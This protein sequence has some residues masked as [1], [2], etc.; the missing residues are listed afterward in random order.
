MIVVAMREY[1][2]AVRT[3][4][5]IFSLLM[6]P[7]MMFGSIGVQILMKDK[8]DTADKRI[9]VIDHTGLLIETIEHEAEKRNTTDI[10]KGE[11]DF[12]EKVRP[13]FVIERV[14]PAGRGRPDLDLA[15]SDRV[16]K[17]EIFAFVIIE[18]DVVD[19]AAGG[20]IAYHSNNATYDDAL[21]WLRGTIGQRVRELRL[22][23]ADIDPKLVEDITRMPD[24]RNLGLA[25]RTASGEVKQAESANEVV[26][27]LVPLGMLML[28]FMMILVGASPLV[29]SVLEEKMNRIAEVL[30]GSVSPFPLMM[31]KLLGMV[32][33]SLTVLTI[34]LFGIAFAVHRAGYGALFPSHLVGWFVAYQVLA[35][36]MFGA[37]FVAIGAAVSDLKEA[38]SL[39]TPVMLIVAA[40]MF[41]WLNVIKEPSS[42]FSVFVSLIPPATP[43][44]MVLRQATPEGVP[45]WQQ[46]LGVS[47]VLATTALCVFAASRI[48]RVGILMQGKGA[49]VT[50]MLRWVL[51]G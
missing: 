26:A 49:K 10:W 5:F 14:D 7:I 42:P 11:G 39:M 17:G 6:L 20:A 18:P 50:E 29:Q 40:P 24:F 15:L 2:A 21:Q 23:K 32:G 12:R 22:A 19:G 47:L 45:L 16:R 8:V 36:L 1:Q 46:V 4:A 41:V 35:V 38:Q 13:A 51:R 34:Y 37:L 44:L 3:K 28:M 33:V 9:A 27:L 43:M 25:E 31:G 48:F 30:L